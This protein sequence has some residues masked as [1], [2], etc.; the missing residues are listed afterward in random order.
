MK[1]IKKFI[2]ELPGEN[3][4]WHNGYETFIENAEAL[5]S[6]NIHNDVIK[7]I[8]EDLYYAVANEYGD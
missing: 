6:Y 5:Q 3:G 4:W 8:L 1:E 7:S 2:M